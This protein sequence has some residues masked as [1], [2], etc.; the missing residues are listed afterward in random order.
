MKKSK[1][2][3]IAGSLVLALT[4][5]FATKANKKFTTVSTAA[6]LVG[7]TTAYY[8]AGASAILT[9]AK[10]GSQLGMLIYCT[11]TSFSESGALN[12]KVS[13]NHAVYYK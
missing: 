5:V 8:V 6:F 13:P 1:V 2:F 11:G 9:T 10:T 7:G 12:E 3:M 4:A